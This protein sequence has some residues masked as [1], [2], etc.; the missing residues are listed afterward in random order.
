MGK[1][2]RAF[3]EL[4]CVV[5]EQ[6]A[7]A[8]RAARSARAAHVWDMCGTCAAHVLQQHRNHGSCVVVAAH[9]VL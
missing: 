8:A 1:Q 3:S 5:P 2:L 6:Q 4:V 7:G 9:L